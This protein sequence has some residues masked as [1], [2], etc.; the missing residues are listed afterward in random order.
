MTAPSQAQHAMSLV[1]DEIDRY[2]KRP[3]SPAPAH[4]LTPMQCI[5]QSP[6]LKADAKAQWDAIPSTPAEIKAWMRGDPVKP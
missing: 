4:G 3:C 1:A 5:D 2:M 6:Q